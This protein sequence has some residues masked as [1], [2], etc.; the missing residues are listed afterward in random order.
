M[1]C[2]HIKCEVK[3]NVDWEWC[4]YGLN[5]WG[6]YG[7]VVWLHSI[8][9]FSHPSSTL[10]RKV[11]YGFLD[12]KTK[13]C[14]VPMVL[15]FSIC[16]GTNCGKSGFSFEFG[17]RSSQANSV[18]NLGVGVPKRIVKSALLLMM[19]HFGQ[20]ALSLQS[21]SRGSKT[22]L[23]SAFRFGNGSSKTNIEKWGVANDNSF[24]TCDNNRM[25]Q[26]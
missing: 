21:G 11:N 8:Q 26:K 22:N 5:E 14:I 20:S 10:D 16:S 18:F 12:L 23:A 19:I 6:S 24:W 1:F 3:H 13:F 17:N 2:T 15:C 9:A 4:I 25:V 7:K